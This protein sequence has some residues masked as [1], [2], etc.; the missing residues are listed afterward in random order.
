MGSSRPLL[1]RG[2]PCTATTTSHDHDTRV[3]NGRSLSRQM[4]PCT[5]RPP[6]RWNWKRGSDGSCT[7]AESPS[8]WRPPVTVRLQWNTL[9]G[10]EEDVRPTR[11]RLRP[12]PTRA[13]GAAAPPSPSK[14]AISRAI[15][16]GQARPYAKPSTRRGDPD[17]NLST[18]N[19]PSIQFVAPCVLLIIAIIGA[20][21]ASS[22][23]CGV[24]LPAQTLAF[25]FFFP[26]C[27][28]LVTL[29]C[30]QT[31]CRTKHCFG[32][33]EYLFSSHRPIYQCS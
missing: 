14:R 13:S 33:L 11:P 22:N 25:L 21:S 1:E 26:F 24:L 32:Q 3:Q 20:I 4:H 6:P 27:H 8:P 7:A 17:A 16:P 10:K 23:T 30:L 2:V 9:T 18:P 28:V 19:R 15:C 12:C 31:P 5:A 29:D